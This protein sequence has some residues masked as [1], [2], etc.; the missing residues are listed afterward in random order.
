MSRHAYLTVLGAT[1]VFAANASAFQFEFAR[2]SSSLGHFSVT[3]PKPFGELPPKVGV[4]RSA[5][6]HPAKSFFIGGKPAP[7]VIF[8]VSK[9]IYPNAADARSI[10]KKLTSHEPPGFMR[11]YMDNV[12]AAGLAGVEIKT[13]SKSAVGYRRIFVAGD[14]VFMLTVEAPAAKDNE[15]K[16]P[17]R[18]FLDSFTLAEPKT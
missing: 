15:I 9:M 7:G 5:G 1:I 17:A 2:A 13:A 18:Q 10:A 14:A 12:H 4:S 8:L 16:A 6:I 11:V 3:L